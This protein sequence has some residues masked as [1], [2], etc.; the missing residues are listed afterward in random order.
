ME[1]KHTK[2]LMLCP[3]SNCGLSE[4]VD[5]SD[6]TIARWVRRLRGGKDRHHTR[7]FRIENQIIQ[8]RYRMSIGGEGVTYSGIL[9]DGHTHVVV[10]FFQ[11]LPTQEQSFENELNALKRIDYGS[12]SHQKRLVA[13]NREHRIIVQNLLPGTP[14]DYYLAQV[15][16]TE[17]FSRL[18]RQY[19]SLSNQFFSKCVTPAC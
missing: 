15:Q 13:S 5:L 3:S 17:V 11:D 9:A 19:L 6:D 4:L 12:P 14:L 18:E 1:I 8:L 2:P 7:S 10:K 16:N